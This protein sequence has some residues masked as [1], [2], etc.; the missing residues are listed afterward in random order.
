MK[1]IGTG[2]YLPKRVLSNDDLSK[3]VDT[4]DE[5]ITPRTGIKE[6]RI[7][8]G[9]ENTDMT[10]NAAKI[11]IENAGI[12]PEEIDLIIVATATNE[13]ITPSVSCIVQDK[14]GAYGSICMDLN[15]ACSGFVYA[16]NTA[17]CYM[18]AGMANT[19]LV[20]GVENLSKITD[21]ADRT[22]CV[23]FGDAAGAVVVRRDGTKKYRAC[24][25]ADAHKWKALTCKGLS[26]ENIFVEKEQERDYLHMNG[27]EVFKFVV[28]VIPK[29][30]KQVLEEENLTENDVDYYLLHQANRRINET[31]AKKLN[32]SFE[33]KFPMN[34]QKTGNTSSATV[35]V[36]LDQL[37]K[38]GKFKEGDKL[39]LCAF[40]GGLT[41]GCALVEW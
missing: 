30:I 9:E 1:I 21:Y 33:E 20:I 32:I 4:S 16:L 12:K 36:L 29:V 17:H 11:A 13:Y 3:I 8:C 10:Y 35:P 37:N 19:A 27:Q 2:S 38:E 6:R 7:S 34:I 18:E 5:W 40:G 14:L 31:V 15:A 24:L 23:L 22:T 25:G 26:V 39:I 41:W 28:K